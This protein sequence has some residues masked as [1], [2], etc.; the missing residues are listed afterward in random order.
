[1]FFKVTALCVAIVVIQAA[2]INSE[3]AA[4]IATMAI[5]LFIFQS[6][7]QIADSLKWPVPYYAVRVAIYQFFSPFFFTLKYPTRIRSTLVSA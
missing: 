2:T 4:S 1:M 5:L 3:D 7:A 6:V